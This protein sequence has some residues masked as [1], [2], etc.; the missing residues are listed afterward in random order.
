MPNIWSTIW[1]IGKNIYLDPNHLPSYQLKNGFYMDLL[2][3][4]RK[5][6][7]SFGMTSTRHGSVNAMQ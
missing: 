5:R 4:R 2:G 1:G 3:V 7:L 6:V